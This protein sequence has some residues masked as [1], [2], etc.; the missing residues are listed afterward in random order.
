MKAIIIDGY[1]FRSC[2]DLPEIMPTVRLLEKHSIDVGQQ[3]VPP[4]NPVTTYRE[5]KLALV[6]IDRQIALY[7]EKGDS[8]A[9]IQSV[10]WFAPERNNYPKYKEPPIYMWPPYQGEQ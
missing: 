4:N 9:L 3:S 1:H 2:V 6:S 8:I 7:S 5:Y 10:T